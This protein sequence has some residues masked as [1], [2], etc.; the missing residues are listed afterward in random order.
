MRAPRHS[1]GA[2]RWRSPALAGL[3]RSRPVSRILS[4]VTISLGGVP[5]SSAGRVT[6]A[7][8]TLHRTGFGE[9]AVSPR[10]LVGS[11][12][13]VSP[14]PASISR[15]RR[16]PF[17]STF[18]RL[19]PPR[20]PVRPALRCPDFP[21]VRLGTRG[22]PA[23]TTDGNAL[24]AT[25]S[26]DSARIDLPSGPA[27]APRTC[28]TNSPHTRHSRLTPRI[29]A[30]SSWSSERLRGATL[31][32]CSSSD[33]PEH[34]RHLAEDLDVLGIEGLECR[35]LRLEADAAVALAVERLDRRF[36]R[37]LVVAD[38][39]HD[40]LAG[41]GVGLLAHDHDVAVEDSGVDHRLALHAQEEIGVAAEGFGHGQL[42][43]D[44]FLGEER[45]TRC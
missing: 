17:C 18:R 20:S 11:Y 2:S 32:P 22:H 40:D 21:R 3:L 8:F 23:C 15:D 9:P 33:A 5:G 10:P 13:T 38:E 44:R 19:S 43:L 37:R 16:S 36:V 35:V 39:R 34:A 4:R 30:A 1:A 6:G 26:S 45:S 27:I 28:N 24:S 29:S 25:S 42:L 31:I 12:P 7:C 41:A 14:L